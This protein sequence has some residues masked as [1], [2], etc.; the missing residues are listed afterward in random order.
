MAE[1]VDALGSGLSRCTPVRVRVPL[2]AYIYFIP[3]D[4]LTFM[5][6]PLL[7]LLN[8]NSDNIPVHE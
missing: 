8:K 1:L 2:A 3:E 7:I 4:P 6:I 5:S